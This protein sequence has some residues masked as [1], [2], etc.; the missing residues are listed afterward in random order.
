MQE[1]RQRR[2]KLSR[3]R[4]ELLEVLGRLRKTLQVVLARS[5]LIKGSVYQI[6]RRCGTPHCRC[7][8]GQLHRNFVLT[9]SDQGRHYMRSLPPARIDEIREKSKEYARFRRAQTALAVMHDQM[10]SLVQ[11]IREL[12]REVP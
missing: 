8:R 5:P 9:W 4:Q 1:D 10:L 3:L 2:Q 7:T 12:R 11:R 6:A